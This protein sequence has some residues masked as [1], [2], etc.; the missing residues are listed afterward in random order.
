MILYNNAFDLYHTIFRILHL[1]NKVSDDEVIE[2]DR[3]RIWDYYLL[4]TNEIFNIKP[5][6]NKKEY[7]QLL[8]KLN[9][10]KNNPYQQI[11]DQRKTLEKIKPYQL[12]ALNCLASYNIIDKEYLFKEEVK[13]NSFDLLKGY[14]QS[15]GD[16]SDREKNIITI[17]TSFFRNISLIGND[18]LKKRSNLMESKYDE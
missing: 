17:M 3:I 7:N 5:I 1:L 11:Y 6:R 4:F 12:S 13:I 9:I 14:I 8:K 2:I 15:V 16:L 10:K 18:G